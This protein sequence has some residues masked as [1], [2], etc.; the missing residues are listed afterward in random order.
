V[1][2]FFISAAQTIAAVQMTNGNHQSLSGDQQGG[3]VK[4]DGPNSYTWGTVLLKIAGTLKLAAQ[5][6]QF[7]CGFVLAACFE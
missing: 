4:I 5:V 7:Q 6:I 3:Q 2:L 1:I